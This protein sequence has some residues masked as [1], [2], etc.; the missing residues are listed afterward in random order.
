MN[1]FVSIASSRL[2]DIPA[3][4]LFRRC[5]CCGVLVSFVAKPCARACPLRLLLSERDAII[6]RETVVGSSTR[7]LAS[8]IQRGVLGRPSLDDFCRLPERV[9][10]LQCNAAREHDQLTKDPAGVAFF[11]AVTSLDAN[12]VSLLIHIHLPCDSDPLKGITG[13]P[14]KG[15]MGMIRIIPRFSVYVHRKYFENQGSGVLE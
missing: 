14:E 7:H 9:F 8:L 11:V 3:A 12:H 13:S 6:G 1:V 10:L 2:Y 15:P 5:D 4:V